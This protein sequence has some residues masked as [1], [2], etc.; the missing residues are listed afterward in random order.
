M[1]RLAMGVVI[2]LCS[3]TTSAA[4]NLSG[5]WKV[6]SLRGGEITLRHTGRKITA[7]RVMYPTFEGKKYKLEHLYRGTIKTG[8][9]AGRLLVKEPELADFE[10]LR[11][12]SGTITSANSVT[13]DGMPLSR[14][15]AGKAARN[16]VLAGLAAPDM[17]GRIVEASF[18]G[19][20]RARLQAA[21]LIRQADRQMGKQRYGEA[22]GL[23]HRAQRLS[24]RQEAKLLRRLGLCNLQLGRRA[25]ARM[26]LGRALKLD[27][28]NRV[29]KRAYQATR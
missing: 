29:L 4:P 17:P 5:V 9:M 10:N 22:L 14:A 20:R 8:K 28:H 26:Y 21:A 3:A 15:G 2:I 18:A 27:P 11:A 19:Q 24:G 23:L 16:A 1:N 25:A 12:F 7:Y 13:L 6:Q